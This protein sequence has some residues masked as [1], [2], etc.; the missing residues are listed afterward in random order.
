MVTELTAG[1]SWHA[2]AVEVHTIQSRYVPQE[3][4]ISVMRPW[5]RKGVAERFPVLYITDANL[6]F[7]FA[8]SIAC[9]LQACGQVQRFVL[10]GIGYPGDHPFC[11]NMLRCRDFTSERRAPTSAP[12][13]PSGIDGVIPF[14][15]DGKRWGGAAD[16][17]AF[18]RHEL[19]ELIDRLY[20]TLP[21]DRAY[22]GHSLGGGLGLHAL[23]AHPGL[24]T[25]FLLTSPSIAYGDDDYGIREARD[26]IESGRPLN[27]QVVLSVG[28][29]EEL[30]SN[31]AANRPRFVSSLYRLTALLR[32]ANIPELELHS[33]VYPGETHA[34]VWPVAF[35]RGIRSIY[36]PADLSPL[37]P[38]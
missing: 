20:P 13:M 4:R 11:G 23:F 21:E 26:C 36:G 29:L 9:S 34:S 17:L 15:G 14:T 38:A 33:H 28:E 6:S 7:G 19:M 8:H 3:Y 5:M 31:P 2:P 25:R 30:D 27:A 12:R 32:E 37:A 10:V 35:S 22:A 18:M 24:F 16:F 1:G